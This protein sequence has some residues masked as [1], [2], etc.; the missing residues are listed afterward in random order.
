MIPTTDTGSMPASSAGCP[1]TAIDTLQRSTEVP[2]AST[3]TNIGYEPFCYRATDPREFNTFDKPTVQTHSNGISWAVALRSPLT[4]VGHIFDPDHTQYNPGAYPT[5]YTFTDSV[6]CREVVTAPDSLYPL[7]A[8]PAQESPGKIRELD[9]TIPINT[10]GPDIHLKV[11]ED[12][13]CWFEDVTAGVVSEIPD[14]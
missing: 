3:F 6:G 1:S 5:T 10:V 9:A 13:S 14:A 4:K 7:S 2:H 12:G 11:R 8:V